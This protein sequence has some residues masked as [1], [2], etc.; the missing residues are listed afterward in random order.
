MFSSRVLLLFLFVFSSLAHGHGPTRQKVKESVVI[1]VP[2]ADSWKMIRNLDF[3]EKWHSVYSSIL[4][5]EKFVK[6]TSFFRFFRPS[7]CYSRQSSCSQTARTGC[8]AGQRQ[9]PG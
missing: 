7:Y 8:G 5:G 4:P 9:L 2:A 3:A 1:N 6:F